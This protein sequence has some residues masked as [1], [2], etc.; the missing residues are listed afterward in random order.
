MINH[1]WFVDMHFKPNFMISIMEGAIPLWEEFKD[2]NSCS[3]SLAY[4]MHSSEGVFFFLSCCGY[5][6]T[7]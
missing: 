5:G 3:I 7:L 2:A 6:K 4:N 1:Y